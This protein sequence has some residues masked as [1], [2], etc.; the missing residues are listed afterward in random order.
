MVHPMHHIKG[1]TGATPMTYADRQQYL[2]DI[3]FRVHEL[4]RIAT[5][6]KREFDRYAS[7]RRL[8][9]DLQTIANLKTQL[10]ALITQD[11]P[12]EQPR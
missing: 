10:D 8:K 7:V 1:T 2:Y 5:R 4:A 12:Q 9:G 6:A 11:A 3:N